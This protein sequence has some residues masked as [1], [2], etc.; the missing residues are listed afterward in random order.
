MQPMQR[1]RGSDP[2]SIALVALAASHSASWARRTHA[3]PRTPARA[4]DA[5]CPSA[6]LAPCLSDVRSVVDRRSGDG[7]LR[8]ARA[9]MDR[10]SR[11]F[12]GSR[13][14]DGLRRLVGAASDCGG[15][16]LVCRKRGKDCDAGRPEQKF[17]TAF[18]ALA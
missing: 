4:G 5:L 17:L 7:T 3:I 6:A 8:L 1:E 11:R 15:G 16:N 9:R 14:E 12:A 2:A 13:V 10:A 18:A